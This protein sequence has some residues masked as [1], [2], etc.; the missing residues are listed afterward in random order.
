MA[1]G[2]DY[3]TGFILEGVIPGVKV[4]AVLGGGRYDRLVGNLG[5]PDLPSVGMAFGLERIMT[6]MTDLELWPSQHGKQRVLI[7]PLTKGDERLL[8]TFAGTLRSQGVAVDYV[9][10]LGGIEESV[11]QYA[12][13]RG[14]THV[15]VH[16]EQMTTPKVVA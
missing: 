2:A 4:G 10:A 12:K 6:A 15:V 1:R 8:F 11:L 7:A 16:E 9:P 5:G 3:Y 13:R 14:F